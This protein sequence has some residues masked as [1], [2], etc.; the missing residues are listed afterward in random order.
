MSW[1]YMI[2]LNHCCQSCLNTKECITIL[3]KIISFDKIPNKLMWHFVNN[4]YSSHTLIE[5]RSDL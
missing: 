1:V 2:N 3:E 4:L 5:T